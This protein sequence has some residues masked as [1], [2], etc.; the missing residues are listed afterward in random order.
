MTDREILE[1]SEIIG[2]AGLDWNMFIGD[3][4]ETGEEPHFSYDEFLAQSILESGYRKERE[5]RSKGCRYC[6]IG[7]DMKN[8][9]DMEIDLFDY[10]EGMDFSVYPNF[11]PMC[12]R[13]LKG[14]QNESICM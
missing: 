7:A 13:K 8:D 1:L 12:G 14:A 9:E 4:Y 3:C 10:A 6:S 2:D 11:C 5:G